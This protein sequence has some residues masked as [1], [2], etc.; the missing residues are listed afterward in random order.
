MNEDIRME[1]DLNNFNDKSN[2]VKEI[3]GTPPNWIIRWGISV[4][5]AII[6][7]ILLGASLISYNDII[8]SR[9]TITSKNPPAYIE[10]KVSG[11][12]TSIFVKPN[13][14]V[15]KGQVLAVIENTANIENVFFLKEELDRFRP[16]LKD[17]D[18]I[19]QRFPSNLDLGMIQPIYNTFRYRYQEYLNYSTFNPEKNRALNLKLQINSKNSTLINVQNQ[20]QYYRNELDNAEKIFRMYEKLHKTNNSSISEEQYL[21]QESLFISAKRN[22]EVLQRSVKS[23]KNEILSLENSLKQTNIDDQSSLFSTDQKLNE[24]H[25]ELK[26]II[27]Q[28]EQEYLIKSPI[29]GRITLFDIWNKYQ[30]VKVGEVLFTVVPEDIQGIV[31]RVKMP[32]KNSGKV[33][34][35]QKVIIKLDNYPY[36]EWGSIEGYISNIS[37]VPKQGEAMYNVLIEVKNLKT[38]YGKTLDFKQEMQG[39][40]EIIV[41]ELTIIQRVFYQL[42]KVLNRN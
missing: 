25:Q 36:Q 33:H 6:V 34:E 15:Q 10:A 39:N 41:E 1:N 13:D 17:F 11:K 8:L 7:S 24:A 42:R 23:V 12:L 3:L 22:F 20:L 21:R 5:L 26:N 18:S 2:H 28:W 32:I 37:S 14:Y 4:I 38:S 40:S 30:N 9:I 27:I 31:G 19:K 29:A 35:G 16:N